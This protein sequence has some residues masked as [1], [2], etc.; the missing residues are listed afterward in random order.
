LRPYRRN[1]VIGGKEGRPCFCGC[2]GDASG[3]NESRL[4]L[5]LLRLLGSDAYR[6]AR[7]REHIASSD[8]MAQ[9]WGLISLAIAR[10][11]GRPIGLD[12]STR[13]A[14]NAAFPPDREPAAIGKPR[15]HSKVSPL[16]ELNR[17]LTAKPPPFRVQFV[18][19]ATHRRRSI[20]KEVEVQVSDISSAIVAAANLTWPPKTIGLRILDRDGREVFERHKADRR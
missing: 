12:T 7:W 3:P 20:L 6:E 4:K 11:C 18:G 15:P 19:P 9:E 14:N 5:T 1:A 8:S 10:K 13:M 17:I 16:D 2:V